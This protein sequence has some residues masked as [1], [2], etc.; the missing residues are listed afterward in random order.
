M[1]NIKKVLAANMKA[2]RKKRGFS[3]A[4]LAERVGTAAHYIGMIETC[5]SFP[6]AE[7]IERIA[8]ALEQDS[9]DLFNF[10]PVQHEWKEM[11]LSDIRVYVEK[12][13]NERNK[14]KK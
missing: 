11:I 6:S 2:Y 9:L 10:C 5:N 14:P 8:A 12:K 3:Q 4:Q 7:M 1:T 13:I